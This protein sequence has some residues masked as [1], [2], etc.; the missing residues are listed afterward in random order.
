E[1]DLVTAMSYISSSSGVYLEMIGE[2]LSCTREE[3]ETDDNYRARI[4]NQVSVMQNANMIAIR[5]KA[6]QVPGV[7]DIQLKRFT[8]GTG[9][10][11]CYVVPQVY[12]IDDNLLIRV[13]DALNE[14]T[15]YGSYVEVKVTEYI[16]VDI[17][18]NLIF[19]SRA[20]SI[21]KEHIRNQVIGNV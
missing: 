10:Y 21:E 14:I 6:L 7:A 17:N 12:P 8:R 13:E 19:S 2:L 18:I 11:T 15:A 20:K 1:L 4:S 9:S 5:L 16:P 3:G